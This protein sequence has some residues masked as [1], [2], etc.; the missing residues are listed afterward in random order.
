M[1]PQIRTYILVTGRD[2]EDR[3]YRALAPYYVPMPKLTDQYDAMSPTRLSTVRRA[4]EAELTLINE[5]IADVE[6][7]I[8]HRLETMP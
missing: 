1:R 5:A 6:F 8:A 7:E 2:Q 4:L 3:P